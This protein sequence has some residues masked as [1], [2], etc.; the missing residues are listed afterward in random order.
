MSKNNDAQYKCHTCPFCEGEGAISARLFHDIGFLFG[1]LF[2]FKDKVL[3]IRSPHQVVTLVYENLKT[4][5][6]PV[7]SMKVSVKRGRRA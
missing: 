3:A 6:L 7:R 4:F 2:A 1:F 5:Q